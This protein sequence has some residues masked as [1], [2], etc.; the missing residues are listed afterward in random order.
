[1]IDEIII[2]VEYEYY[3]FMKVSKDEFMRLQ[4]TPIAS[5]RM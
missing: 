3:D 5:S 2:F 1:M 4:C